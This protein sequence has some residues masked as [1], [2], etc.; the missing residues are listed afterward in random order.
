MKEKVQ[1]KKVWRG[2]ISLFALA[3][4]LWLFAEGFANVS[5]AASAAKVTA[6]AANIRAEASA[7]STAV[8]SV[9]LDDEIE[10]LGQTVGG[11]GKVWYQVYVNSTSTGY[12]RSDLVQITDGSTP[13]S[14]DGGNNTTATPTPSTG[15]TAS[16]VEAEQVTPVGGK[17]S[18][19]NTVR[20]RTSPSTANNNNVL[21]S[22]NSGTEVTVVARA[23]GADN[24]VWYQIKFTMDNQEAIGYI[25]SDY[26]TLSG[27]L[28]PL[29]EV[30]VTPPEDSPEP[31]EPPEQEEPEQKKRY[32]TKFMK[33]KWYILDYEAG[34]QYEID[35]LFSAAD[36]YKQLYEKE[37]EKAGSGVWIIVLAILAVI[38]LGGDLYLLYRLKEYKESAFIASIERNTLSGRART[39]E[40]PRDGGQRTS[41]SKPVIRE[42]SGG[43]RS[44]VQHPQGQKLA[45]SQSGQRT[46]NPQ[47]QR[48]AEKQGPQRS[49][50][51]QVQRT[52]G[53]QQP[54]SGQVRK[55]VVNQGTQ[56]T[57]NGQSQRTAGSQ[58]PASGQVQRTA[59][60]QQPASG[61]SQ[62]TAG[63]QR[64]SNG[65]VQKPVV[66]QGEQR[67]A[68][69]QRSE[70]FQ[71]QRSG[72]A[73]EQRTVRPQNPSSA[74]NYGK[75][76]NFMS[77][78]DDV[79]FEVLKLDDDEE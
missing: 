65:Q 62:R 21:T 4:A 69:S 52:A 50:N 57:T 35:A 48:T 42:G 38:F 68:G 76:I 44:G 17:V 61:Q 26:V 31:T 49:A 37:K 18:G 74:G 27:E 54:A 16:N 9:K 75:S 20:V 60:S 79:D 19:S 67:T 28:T 30:Q 25:R 53:N 2:S 22:V 14:L 3:F 51:S 77:D 5:Q 45:D 1:W 39:S 71:G 32:E 47:G 36:Q 33:D 34:Q 46:V 73:P 12:I 41:G 8:G 78:E 64:Q 23:T 6:R 70:S 10:I 29:S 66:N 13:P 63:S 15:N 11:D 58:Q 24:M 55:P 72:P 56:R 40:R 59:G 43:Q 7:S